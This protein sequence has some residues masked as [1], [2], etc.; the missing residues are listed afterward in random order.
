MPDQ[1]P[2]PVCGTPTRV[3]KKGRRYCPTCD[4]WK[5]SY[6]EAYWVKHKTNVE[7]LLKELEERFPQVTWEAAGLGAVSGAR[8]DIPA[9]R[10]GEEDIKGW[11]MRMHF[12]S[13]EVTGSDSPNISVPPDPIYIRPGKLAEAQGKTVPFFFYLVYPRATYVVDMAMVQAHRHQVTP[14][15]IRGKTETYIALPCEKAY[16]GEHL[17]VFISDLLCRLEPR[18][19]LGL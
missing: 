3:D 12:V 1:V 10:K 18:Q 8:L 11:W 5:P 13:I 6:G 15:Q 19:S 4:Y 9:H 14:R 7:A 16:P 2:C 17:F